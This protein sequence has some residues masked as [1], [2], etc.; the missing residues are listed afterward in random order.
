VF[1]DEDDS[2]IDD[3]NDVS[4]RFVAARGLDSEERLIRF[5]L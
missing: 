1:L 5:A 2:E 3:D 4:R